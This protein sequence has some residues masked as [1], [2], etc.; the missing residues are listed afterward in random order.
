MEQYLPEGLGAPCP[1]SGAE[2]LYAAMQSHAILEATAACCDAD[3]N[4]GVPLGPVAGVIP[5]AE[6]A[7]NAEDVRDIAILSRVG[8]PVCFTVQDL[9]S[10]NGRLTAVL[11]R[12]EA[13]L[14]ALDA[15]FLHHVPGDI[16]DAVVT[17]LAPFGAFCDIGCGVTALLHLSRI[18]VSRLRHSAERFQPGQHIHAAILSMDPFSRRIYLTHRELL[19]TWEENA[20]RF[21]PGQAVTGVVRT[22]RP[23]GVFIELSPNLSGL[24]EPDAALTPGQAVSVY[25]KAIQPERR[26]L[27]LAVIQR[28]P[29]APPAP[30]R[31]QLTGGHLEHWDYGAQGIFT[32]F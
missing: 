3:H 5:R 22:V 23:Y 20:A 13:Q 17:S 11:S 28:L 1:G 26:K 15:F 2:A 12:R 14:R 16:V 4:L 19:G 6:A 25:I 30:L 32:D 18:C 8:L 7:W 31:Y 29:S 10:Q 21:S 27:K 9:R 24:S